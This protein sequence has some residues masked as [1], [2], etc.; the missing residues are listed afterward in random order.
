L[1]PFAFRELLV[2]IRALAR[3]G[4]NYA[5]QRIVLRVADQELDPEGL[6]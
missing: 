4:P 5:E 1:K 2:R 6:G 3:R